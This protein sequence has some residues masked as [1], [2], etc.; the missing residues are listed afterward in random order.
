MILRLH[1]SIVLLT[2]VAAAQ[3]IM[4]GTLPSAKAPTD[5]LATSSSQAA[6]PI[7]GKQ[8]LRWTI[9][10]T[11]GPES[12]AAGLFSAGWGTLFNHPEE[13]GPHWEGFGKRYGMRLPGV[14]VSNTMEAGLGAFWG[15]DPRYTR[16]AGAPFTHRVGHAVEMT[17]MAKSRDGGIMP[18]YGRWI[19]VPGSN[20]LAKT[21]L[22]DSQATVQHAFVGTGLGFLGRLGGNVFEEFWPDVKQKVFHRGP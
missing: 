21:W 1:C 14:A 7:T 4:P 20:F 5:P 11:V 8:R 17:F 12:L 22:P 16:D 15:E 18:A 3:T 9:L 2:S 10:S 13:Y 19:A 6:P